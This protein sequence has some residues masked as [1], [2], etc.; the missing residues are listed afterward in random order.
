MNRPRLSWTERELLWRRLVSARAQQPVSRLEADQGARAKLN[1]TW[2]HDG[3]T[4]SVKADG[5]PR[6]AIWAVFMHFTEVWGACLNSDALTVSCDEVSVRMD[7]FDV[8]DLRWG[9]SFGL[10]L[11]LVDVR[12]H[13]AVDRYNQRW[14][15][16][17]SGSESRFW[18]V[19]P[20][21]APAEWESGGEVV[22]KPLMCPHCSSPSPAY[23]DGT[24]R[25]CYQWLRRN[26]NR[27]PPDAL[28]EELQKRVRLRRL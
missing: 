28:E 24:C 13:D 2:K 15:D 7:G 27:Y 17:S 5:D 21:A 1:L 11:E 26:R 4:V 22:E 14:Q 16:W 18:N 20:P 10:W 3:A 19:D 23:K 8:G 9:M 6:I 12:R 25:S